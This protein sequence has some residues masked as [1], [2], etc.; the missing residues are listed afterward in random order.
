MRLELF[1]S[2]DNQN[3]VLVKEFANVAR[4][5][6]WSWTWDGKLGDGMGVLRGKGTSNRVSWDRE[7]YVAECDAFFNA[8]R[9]S[10]VNQ[11]KDTG[12]LNYREAVQAGVDAVNRLHHSGLWKGPV[13][14]PVL[15]NE[16]EV[17]PS[18][19]RR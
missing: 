6:T 10:V 8:L 16:Q 4:P 5:G 1:D 15:Y 7:I 19:I 12:T 13:D 18:L 11:I 17:I 2:S 14:I 3:P 9:D